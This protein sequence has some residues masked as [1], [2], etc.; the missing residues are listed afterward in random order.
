LIHLVLLFAES[1]VVVLIVFR[2]KV[3]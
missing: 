1:I 2:Y 3:F